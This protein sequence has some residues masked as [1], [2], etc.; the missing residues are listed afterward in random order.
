MQDLVIEPG[1]AA[2]PNEIAT[3]LELHR[4][5]LLALLRGP[6]TAGAELAHRRSE[7]MGRLLATTFET[8]L[9]VLAPTAEAPVVLGAVGGFGRGLL[10]WKSDSTCA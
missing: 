9:G 3:F 2:R 10:G 1:R 5:E 4:L 8:S 6:A 7:V